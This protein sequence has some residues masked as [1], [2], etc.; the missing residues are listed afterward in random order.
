MHGLVGPSP[1][2]KGQEI[3]DSLGAMRILNFGK[4]LI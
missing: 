1:S 3:L 2:L 4:K